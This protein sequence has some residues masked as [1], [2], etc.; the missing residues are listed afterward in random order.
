LYGHILFY[1]DNPDPVERKTISNPNPKTPNI[2]PDWT[3]KS[4]SCT[5]LLSCR[6]S[7][8]QTGVKRN[9]LLHAKCACTE[10]Y[11]TYQIC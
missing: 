7:N 11:S 10:Q 1:L 3:L 5:P 9:F 6:I 4:G 8:R 2:R